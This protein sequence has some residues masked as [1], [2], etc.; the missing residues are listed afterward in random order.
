MQQPAP[1]LE[2]EA[3]L[4]KVEADELLADSDRLYALCSHVAAH[5]VGEEPYIDKNLM[6]GGLVPSA[7]GVRHAAR[8]IAQDLQRRLRGIEHHI[9]QIDR[10]ERIRDYDQ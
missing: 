5:A 8:A 9:C 7:L 2:A 6:P 4:L 10:A 3:T 1:N